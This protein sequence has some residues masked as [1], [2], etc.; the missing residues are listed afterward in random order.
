MAQ[1]SGFFNAL[2]TGTTYDRQYNANDYSD[3]IGAIITT[4]VRRSGDN[5]LYVQASGGMALSINAGRAWIEGKWYKNDTAFTDFSVPTAPT[6]DRGRVDRVVLKLDNSVS[7]RLIELVYKTG[8]PA[9]DPTAP[10]L[11][12]SGDVYEIALAD[13]AVNPNV[14]TITQSDIYDRRPHTDVCGWI[15]SPVGYDDYFTNLDTEFNTWFTN[16]KDTLAS[17]TMVKQ[18]TWSEMI[19]D[20][21]APS[22]TFNI[23][24]YD[25]T[26]TDIVKVVKQ[27]GTTTTILFQ[28]ESGSIGYTLSGSTINFNQPQP[29]GTTIHVFVYKSIDGTGL[30]S[31]SDEVTTLQNDIAKINE[32]TYFCNG[33]TDNVELSNIAQNFLA[34]DTDYDQMTVY[35]R[36]TFG[37]TSPF[38]GGG[39]STS[40]YRWMS[41]G[42]A[43]TT[44]K[45][46]IFDFANC[47]KITLNCQ[48]GYHYIGV[49]GSGVN[50][51]NANIEA[52]CNYIGSSFVMFSATTT[53]VYARDCRFWIDGESRCYISVTGTFDHCKATVINASS[54]E[55]CCFKGSQN[56]LLRINGGEYYSYVSDNTVNNSFVI[57]SSALNSCIIT[58]G[59]NCPTVAKSGFKQNFAIRNTAGY[60]AANDTITTLQVNNTASTNFNVRGTYAV[61]LPDR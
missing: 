13:I 28:D 8:T 49:Y 40:R 22:V 50:I 32:F 12:R 41:L 9:A 44:K 31:V 20:P 58:N 56:C 59:M 4:G 39:T 24:Q 1:T 26:G 53:E 11:E 34:S 17:V 48:S 46:I 27:V 42:A 45:R 33:S 19:T 5:D 60:G 15:T 57:D 52:N 25:P 35:V 55:S 37:A 47:S 16:T 23:P 14:T 38:A 6:G 36:G 10:E 30:G 51:L 7:G 18:Y 43:G 54:T 3:N 2:K 21:S 29:L 61:N